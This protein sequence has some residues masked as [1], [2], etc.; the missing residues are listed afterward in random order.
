[1]WSPEQLANREG[2]TMQI[3]LK[4]FLAHM[5]TAPSRPRYQSRTMHAA[6]MEADA[7]CARSDAAL[8]QLNRCRLH[9]MT[10]KFS[11]DTTGSVTMRRSL[12]VAGLVGLAI[13][14]ATLMP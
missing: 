8:Q 1:M 3:E 10:D 12:A 13:G 11:L 4:G 7:R 2:S 14:A 9:A 6:F 5:L